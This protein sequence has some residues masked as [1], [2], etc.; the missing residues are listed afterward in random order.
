M[1]P[2]RVWGK[3][4]L[5]ENPDPNATSSDY[6]KT[7]NRLI[8]ARRAMALCASCVTKSTLMRMDPQTVILGAREQPRDYGLGRTS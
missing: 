5:L 2:M 1:P 4:L 8:I 6:T 7:F 3:P